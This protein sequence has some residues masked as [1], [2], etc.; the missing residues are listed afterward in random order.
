M[1]AILRRVSKLEGRGSTAESI[2]RI[3]GGFRLIGGV[4]GV[5]KVPIVEPGAW[6][7]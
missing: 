7:K 5:L 4:K 1:K 3:V 6:N 2:N